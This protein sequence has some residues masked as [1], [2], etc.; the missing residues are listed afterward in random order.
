V[1]GAILLFGALSAV[2]MV[3]RRRRNEQAND[4]TSVPFN[5]EAGQAHGP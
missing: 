2:W 1:V 3:M 5:P 4:T